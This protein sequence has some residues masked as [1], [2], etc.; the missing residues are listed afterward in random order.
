MLTTYLEMIADEAMEPKD[1]A[2]HSPRR[3]VTPRPMG[4][5]DRVAILVTILGASGNDRG[6]GAGGT[7]MVQ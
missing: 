1:D 6:V 3:T 4:A 7:G 2:I 5:S